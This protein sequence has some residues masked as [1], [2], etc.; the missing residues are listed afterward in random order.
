MSE[1][2][3]SAVEQILLPDESGLGEGWVID[4]RF[5]NVVMRVVSKEDTKTALSTLESIFPKGLRGK[6]LLETRRKRFNTW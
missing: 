3:R 2:K 5:T 4:D 6:V 1:S